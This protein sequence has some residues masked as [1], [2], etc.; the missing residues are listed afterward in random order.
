MANPSTR[1]GLID[2]CLRELGHPVLEINIDDDQLEDRLDEAL[3]FYRDFHYDAV[4]L[5]Y[6]KHQV[7]QQD[8]N[9]E[10]I[11]INDLI[12]GVEKVVP[13]T[14]RTRGID[15]FDVRYQILLNDIY[16]IQSTDII[17]YSQVKTQL[18]LL[19]QLLVGE[20]PIRFNR[21]TNR[22]YISMDWNTDVTAGE[23]IIVQCYRVLDPSTYSDVYNDS[24]LKKYTTA[25]FKKQW[26]NNLKKFEGVQLP[27]FIVFGCL[28]WRKLKF[29]FRAFFRQ[30]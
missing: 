10:Y 24:F 2:Y 1:Q 18:E 15:L 29:L 27:V 3:Q 12:I 4:E 13:F 30:E 23:Y 7:T 22:L 28:A 5:V 26:G 25:L 19:N 16:S 20:K 9:N 8:I 11:S 21:H 17:Y 14:S 6:L